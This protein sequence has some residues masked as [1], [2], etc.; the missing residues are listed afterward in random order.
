MKDP[1]VPLDN[2]AVVVL[3]VSGQTEVTDL[4]HTVI[5]QQDVPRCNVSVDALG[6]GTLPSYN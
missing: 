5:R 1:H 2:V 3:D 4:C 6:K